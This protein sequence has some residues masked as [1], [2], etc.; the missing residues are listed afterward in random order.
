[1]FQE[2]A[3]IKAIFRYPIKSMAGES[4]ASAK[5]GWHGIEGDRRFALLRAGNESGFPWLTAGRLPKLLQYRPVNRSANGT[6]DL[7]THVITPGGRE[8]ELRSEELRQELSNAFGSPVEMIRLDQG[9]FD[10]AKVSV[11]S[12]ATIKAIGKECELDLEV[13]RFRP[14]L[15]IET[16]S[17]TP[18]AE[19]AWVGKTIR[20]Q[21][22]TDAAGINVSMR[23]LRCAMINL[24][25]ETGTSNP[26][27]LKAVVKLNGNDAGVYAAI[28]GVGVLS[29]GDRLFLQES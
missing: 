25:P 11:I 29:V 13:Q 10:E 3:K 2:I 23:D 16:L 21:A 7:P 14:N 8:M 24:D 17:G 15:L 9:I 18:F 5:L 27:V 19:D 26:K 20:F 22:R 4:L 1:M 12:T 6:E 28:V